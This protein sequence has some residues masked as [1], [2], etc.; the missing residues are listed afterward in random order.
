MCR[1]DEERVLEQQEQRSFSQKSRE[2]Q[3]K[4]LALTR[5]WVRAVTPKQGLGAKQRRIPQMWFRYFL[6]IGTDWVLE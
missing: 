2:I 6:P 5:A 3:I 4:A 1:G